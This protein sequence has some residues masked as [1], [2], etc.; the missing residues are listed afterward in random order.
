VNG[1]TEAGADVDGRRRRR[2]EKLSPDPAVRL[3]IVAAAAEITRE[4]GIRSLNVAGVLQRCELSTRAFYRHFASKDELVTAL[5]LE[6]ART[7]T[8]RL[9]RKMKAAPTAVDAVAAW[10]DARLDLAFDPNIKSDLRVLSEEAQSLMLTAPPLIDAAFAEM[11]APLVEQLWRGLKDRV[12][13]DIEPQ[14]SAQIIQGAVWACTT[15]QWAIGDT[16]RSII[17]TQVVQSCLR[18]LGVA[19]DSLATVLAGAP[20][21]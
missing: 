12:F 8:R 14:T 16:E 18:G 9:R 20:P 7:E 21:H 13:C 2:R 11:L 15:R 6:I 10:I 17:R 3:Q 4:G 1:V 19:A 5:F